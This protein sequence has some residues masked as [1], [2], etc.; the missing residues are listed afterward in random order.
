MAAQTRVETDSLGTVRVP[1][2]CYWGAGTQRALETFKIGDQRMP[3]ALIRALGQQKLAAA[4]ANMALGALDPALGAAI[5]EAAQEVAAGRLT[6]HFPLPVWQT[7]SATQTHMNVNEVIAGRA[8]HRLTGQRGGTTPVHP[9]DHVNMGQSSND[10]VPTAMHVATLV[11]VED[12]L[13]PALATLNAALAA[14]AGEFEDMVKLGQEVGAWPGQ[15]ADAARHVEAA[16][17]PLLA[18]AQGDTGLN[19]RSRFAQAF[20]A[21]LR[22]LT[23]KPFR[24]AEDKLALIAA[25]D[26]LVAVSATLNDLA[27]ALLKIANDVR[28]LASGPGTS[29]GEPTQAEALAMVAAQVMGNHVAI[30]IAGSRGEPRLGVFKPVLIHNLL[31]SIALLADGAASFA[32]HGIAGPGK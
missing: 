13:L 15:V 16:L 30:T 18:L 11:E 6:S 26:A 28:L 24:P 32:R 17:P 5:V 10:S 21:E 19:A 9:S 22:A 2:H 7:G 12:R 4:R 27:A 1:A 20:A 29:L 23:G 3:E 25:H 8:N 31:Q 14:K